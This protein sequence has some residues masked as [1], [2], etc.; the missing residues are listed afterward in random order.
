M[1]FIKIT[2]FIHAINLGFL[3]KS[4]AQTSYSE[5]GIASYYASDFHGKRTASGEKYDMN[6]LTAAHNTLPFHSYVKVTNLKNNKSVIVRI[7]DR[8]P[9]T[10][11]RI[12]DLSKAAAIKI[13]MIQ[14]G[15]AKVIIEKID[16]LE[17]TGS[18]SN[19]YQSRLNENINNFKI[20][21]IYDSLGKEVKPDRF[22]VQVISF[23]DK[24]KIDKE[25][26]NLRAKIKNIYIEVFEIDSKKVYRI[27]S[28][29]FISKESAQAELRRLNKIGYEG[30]IREFK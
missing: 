11:K 27:L 15:E 17:N 22:A 26:E 18:V 30:L 24:N 20:G 4:N 19:A 6:S 5:N 29:A 3:I 8:G 28:G 9:H 25:I 10:K 13:G 12:I 16:S 23:S 7:N 1:D 21:H 14:S 2:L